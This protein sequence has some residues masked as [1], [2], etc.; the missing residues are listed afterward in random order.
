[1]AKF[2]GVYEDFKGLVKNYGLKWGSKNSD[3]LVIKRLL[4]TVDP[5]EVF[6]WVK[7]VKRRVPFLGDFMDLMTITGLRYNEAIESSN[8]IVKLAGEGRLSEYF[9]AEEL[10]L[11]HYRFKEVFIRRSK[12]VF[13]SFVPGELVKRISHGEPLHWNIVKK[14]VARRVEH[15]RFA[16]IREVNAS[17]VTKHLSQPEIDFLQGRV[18]A[19]VFMRHYFNPA[20]ITDL[21]HRALKAAEEILAKIR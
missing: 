17:V 14:K 9:N 11:E 15:L 1:L 5:N 19:S 6:D 21:K 2:L 18:S 16:D 12:K 3:M 8:L 7:S 20:W 13:I 4:K 10:V